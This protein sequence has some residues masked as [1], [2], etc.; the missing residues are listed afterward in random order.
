MR[1]T[2]RINPEVVKALQALGASAERGG[3][4]AMTLGLVHLRATGCSVGVD[5][6]PRILK[7]TGE[8][9]ERLFAVA[10]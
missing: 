2:A 6:H 1:I 3:V 4:P 5:M 7:K 10:A 8:T 9:D